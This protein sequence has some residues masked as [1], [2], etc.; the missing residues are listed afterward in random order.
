MVQDAQGSTLLTCDFTEGKLVGHTNDFSDG[1]AGSPRPPP[2]RWR[3]SLE[4][5]GAALSLTP[6]EDSGVAIKLCSAKKFR[7]GVEG[8]ASHASKHLLQCEGF[9][10]PFFLCIAWPHRDT[11]SSVRRV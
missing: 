10:S 9:A 8:T 11:W 7:A 2:E 4:I 5:D 1:V 3:A 6:E